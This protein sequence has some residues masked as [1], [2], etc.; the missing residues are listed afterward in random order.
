[1][2]Q[3]DNPQGGMKTLTYPKRLLSTQSADHLYIFLL[4]LII[5]GA[6]NSVTC[7]LFITRS[8]VPRWHI[9]AIFIFILPIDWRHWNTCWMD[10]CFIILIHSTSQNV[11]FSV[12]QR[13]THI[14]W[15]PWI[16]L[17][18]IGTLVGRKRKPLAQNKGTYIILIKGNPSLFY[19]E[20]QLVSIQLRCWGSE[21][22]NPS[23][24]VEF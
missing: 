6:Y 23:F 17:G 21:H 18:W 12:C 3:V 9:M 20:V 11:S 15:H 2:G 14:S 13:G 4:V 10:K 24:S 7:I 5:F 8:Q 16:F 1:M 22:S 19:T